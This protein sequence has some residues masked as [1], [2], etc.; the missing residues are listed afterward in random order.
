MFRISD[1]KIL[2]I[3]LCIFVVTL[4]LKYLL[5][6]EIVTDFLLLINLFFISIW[7]L[8]KNKK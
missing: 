1:T 4:A 7:R 3:I 2:N 5:Q 8:S 6:S